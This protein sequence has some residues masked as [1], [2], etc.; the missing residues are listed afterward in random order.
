MADSI[1]DNYRAQSLELWENQAQVWE[2]ER[3][4][5]WA[6]SQEVG[7]W[8]VDQLQL[9]PGDTVLEIAAGTGET[10]YQAARKVG[11]SGK[12]IS[13][14][15]SGEMVE[16]ARNGGEER[17]LTNIEYRVM[18]AE[19]M[20]LPDD[21]VD[22]VI[23]RWG[24]ML[25]AD[26]DLAFAQTRRVLRPGGRVAFSVWASPD[27]NQWSFQP[28]ALMVERGYLEAPQPGAPGI[29]ALADKERIRALVTGAGFG[30]PRIEEVPIS[31]TFD[32]FDEFW[33]FMSRM[34]GPIAFALQKLTDEQRAQIRETL[35]E[36]L[37]EYNRD[38]SF[39]V[40]GL[41]LNVVAE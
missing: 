29:F 35:R 1:L 28:A 24:Y 5:M 3:E 14:D 34:A 39:E 22:G 30:E 6:V 31:W 19:H 23:C 41:C 21:S 7:T 8:L 10:G 4:F 32:S 15:F 27:R 20:D 36:R 11:D 25:M 18:D 12:V 40:P 16:A 37:S 9:E 33:G 2:A 38:G 26:P 13:T 17:G